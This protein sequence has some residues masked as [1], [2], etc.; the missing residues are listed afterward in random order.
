MFPLLPGLSVAGFAGKKTDERSDLEK[1]FVRRDSLAVVAQ[2]VLQVAAGTLLL[3]FAEPTA[4]VRIVDELALRSF[5]LATSAVKSRTKV[6]PIRWTHE[7][8]AIIDLS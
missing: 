8:E 1:I 7:L 6:I 4:S 5:E 2:E 3:S